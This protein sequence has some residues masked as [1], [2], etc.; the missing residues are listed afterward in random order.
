[1]AGNIASESR[2]KLPA[3]ELCVCGG[4]IKCGLTEPTMFLRNVRFA[5]LVDG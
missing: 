2:T 5:V 1:M 4:D 3:T